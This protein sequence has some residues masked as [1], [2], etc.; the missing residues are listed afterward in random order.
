[1]PRRRRK[2]RKTQK[3]T[4]ED[5]ADVK[6]PKSFVIR[7]GK[8]G[9]NVISLVR[10]LREVMMPHTAA[11]L[12]E[13]KKNSLKDFVNV[14]P[15]LN[16]THMLVFSKSAVGLNLR[17]L[18]VPRGPTLTFRV[19]KFSLKQD[20]ACMQRKPHTP[21][22]RELLDAP[23]VVL[24]N[25]SG[26]AVETRLT[27]T[28]FQ[29]M[30][31]PLDVA[32][33]QLRNCRRVLLVHR[34]L[35]DGTLELRHFLVRAAPTGISRSVK[36]IVRARIPDLGR[37]RDISE[38]VARDGAVSDSEAEEN[39]ENKLRLPQNLAGRGNAAA[40]RS[41][42]RLKEIG[43]RLTLQLLKIEEGLSGGA[44]LYHAFQTRTAAET[45]A[46]KKKKQ[47][48]T[49]LRKA[50]RDQ[51]Q[52]NVEAK[53]AARAEKARQSR[54]AAGL[55]A[56]RD[57]DGDDDEPRSDAE[58]YRQEVGEEPPE[59]EF[60]SKKRGKKRRG[61][62]KGDDDDDDDTAEAVKRGVKG[63]KRRRRSGSKQT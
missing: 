52:A 63:K 19:L 49:Q 30:F 61:G 37:L 47:Q 48:E 11:A 50:R 34:N 36:K 33:L 10:N 40:Q 27:A 31:P 32:N 8:V 57:D 62:G 20:I 39:P 38:F 17:L 41:A 25:F 2:K 22:D 21:T 54:L 5:E 15:T 18:R 23:L 46:L 58:W 59:E 55:P 1:M 24:N 43:P 6:A 7:R 13:N 51:Q 60:A 42:I 26:D 3:D 28:M 45:Q 9:K 29:S 56:E 14:A 16:V 12:K 35:T 44:T 53:R 4:A